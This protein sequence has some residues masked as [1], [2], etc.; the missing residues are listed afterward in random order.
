MTENYA[1]VGG[2]LEIC[3]KKMIEDNI[4]VHQI[5]GALSGWASDNNVSA[6]SMEKLLELLDSYE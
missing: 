1:T 4:D 3:L 6:K 2:L 5:A